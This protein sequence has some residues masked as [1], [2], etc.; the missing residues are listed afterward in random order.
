AVSRS[1]QEFFFSDL[2]E[3]GVELLGNDAEEAAG[4]GS[5]RDRVVAARLTPVASAAEQLGYATVTACWAAERDPAS[6]FRSADADSY[7]AS[8][9]GLA[10]SLRTGA[11]PRRIE[12]LDGLPAFAAPEVAVLTE[13]LRDRA[14]GNLPR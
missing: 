11:A 13:A 12:R 9:T 4:S 14:R 2:D 6:V 7:L 5:R 3:D 1:Y 10:Q 8:L